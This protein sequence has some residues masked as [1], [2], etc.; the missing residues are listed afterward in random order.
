MDSS[1]G[2]SSSAAAAGHKRGSAIAALA[3]SS[4]ASSTLI[5]EPA[6]K[7]CR[8]EASKSAAG[9]SASA[10]DPDAASAASSSSSSLPQLPPPRLSFF[11][12][13]QTLLGALVP[14]LTRLQS[15]RRAVT[16]PEEAQVVVQ[17]QEDREELQQLQAQLIDREPPQSQQEM[18][19][20]V[21]ELQIWIQDNEEWL[22]GMEGEKLADQRG[23]QRLRTRL[24]L[25][26][27]EL[28]AGQ[29]TLALARDIHDCRWRRSVLLSRHIPH[30][31]TM[32]LRRWD[33]RACLLLAQL[34]ASLTAD[35]IRS[36]PRLVFIC[37]RAGLLSAVQRMLHLTG[38]A[39]AIETA[40]GDP[41]LSVLAAEP[42]RHIVRLMPLL[43][44]IRRGLD[45]TL[46]SN[47]YPQ[48]ALQLARG[49][50]QAHPLTS[51]AAKSE[52]QAEMEQSGCGSDMY[53][54]SG[55]PRDFAT[56]YVTLQTASSWLKE[57]QR[58]RELH[59]RFMHALLSAWRA[60][61]SAVRALLLD[62][63]PDRLIPDLVNICAEYPDLEPA[64]K[65]Q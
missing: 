62:A 6:L 25:T 42:Q 21:A 8:D 30:D 14:I 46:A 24:A 59:T 12:S 52:L 54:G 49:H 55:S 63:A 64:E 16:A 13:V 36:H 40:S 32:Q 29:L 37:A 28:S 57:K 51:E 3:D 60:H 20:R 9:A 45:T 11:S 15:L 47:K 58:C 18:Q 27:G 56:D 31:L 38:T 53:S 5:H 7:K 19:S 48:S 44:F 43:H 65:H 22:V 17:L 50:V 61:S 41:Y 10:T 1:S 33:G 23:L 2:S 26:Q 34:A 4:S 35:E 39:C